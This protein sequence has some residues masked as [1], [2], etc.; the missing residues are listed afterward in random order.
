MV[1]ED[2]AEAV[3]IPRCMGSDYNWRMMLQLRIPV[4]PRHRPIAHVV[5]VFVVVVVQSGE[6]NQTQRSLPSRTNPD[7][8]D[9]RA[10][11][12]PCRN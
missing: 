6:V 10:V 12:Y 7:S 9:R 4:D 3:R 1:E 8:E 5:V 2:K 11:H